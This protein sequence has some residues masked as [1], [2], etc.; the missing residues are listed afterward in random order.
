MSFGEK[1]IIRGNQKGGKCLKKRKKGE[2]K[3]EKMG[4]KKAK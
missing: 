2:R 4:S 1:N 3:R